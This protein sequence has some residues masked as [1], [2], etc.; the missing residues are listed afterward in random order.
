MIK[1]TYNKD[2]KIQ[3]LLKENENLKEN[4]NMLRRDELQSANTAN[5]GVTANKQS[6]NNSTPQEIAKSTEGK[7]NNGLSLIKKM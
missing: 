7:L 6:E 1:D 5:I 2:L 3:N 4:L